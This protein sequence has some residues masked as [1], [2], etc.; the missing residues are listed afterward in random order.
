MLTF[1]FYFY[2]SAG[3][4]RT[5]T[6]IV[7]QSLFH[8]VEES[9]KKMGL[10]KKGGSLIG[11]SVSC[12]NAR[13]SVIT[14]EEDGV[15]LTSKHGSIIAGNRRLSDNPSPEDI[16]TSSSD[17]ALVNKSGVKIKKRRP[18]PINIKRLVQH[19][20]DQRASM[21]TRPEQVCH[22]PR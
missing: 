18:P 16:E 12:D 15:F 17:P 10:D 7:I 4:G 2:Y 22:C 14:H 20:R 3:V 11:R 1:S 5:G 6:F 9:L 21:L 13:D 19:I 8:M